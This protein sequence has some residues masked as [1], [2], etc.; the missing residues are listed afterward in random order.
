MLRNVLA[1]L[2]TKQQAIIMGHAVPMPVVIRTRTYDETFYKEI[3]RDD[4]GGSKSLLSS[5]AGGNN[6]TSSLSKA[7]Y[8]QEMPPG[9]EFDDL[10]K[11][12]YGE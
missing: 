12:L 11:E 5:G 4:Y 9:K 10:M 3:T 1:S 2:D 8:E 6:S 7:D